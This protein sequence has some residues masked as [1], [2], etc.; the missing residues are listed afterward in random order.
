MKYNAGIGYGQM[1]IGVGV[2][3]VFAGCFIS[4]VG[5]LG[6]VLMRL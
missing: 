5:I 6:L 3:M 4:A 2:L 1:V